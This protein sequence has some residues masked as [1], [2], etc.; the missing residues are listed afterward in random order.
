M[1]VRVKCESSRSLEACLDSEAYVLYF[2]VRTAVSKPLAIGDQVVLGVWSHL[3][4]ITTC[5]F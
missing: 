1:A 5:L 2:D 4:V 3:T